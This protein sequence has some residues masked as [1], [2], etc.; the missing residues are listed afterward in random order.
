MSLE[1]A[2]GMKDDK[3]VIMVTG[4]QGEPTSI[5]GRLSAGSHRQIDI[6]KGDTVVLSSHPIPGNEEN[7]SRT[8]NQL[9]AR[10][11]EV[12]YEGLAPVHVSGHASQEEMKLMMHLTRPK[13]FIPIHGE[14]RQLHQHAQLAKQVGI[15]A[16]NISILMNGQSVEFFKG[17]MKLGPVIPTS[18]VFVD[19]SGVGLVNPDVMREREALS[20]DGVLIVNL[21]MDKLTG[22]VSGAPEVVSKGFIVMSEANDMLRELREKIATTAAHANGNLKTDIE[23]MVGNYMYS[24]IRRRPVVIVNVSK[25]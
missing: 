25:N 6:E 24:E 9:F 15:P 16:E 22:R 19:A 14:L 4:S 11:A 2:L 13:Y 10:G 3:V 21:S 5:L 7:V 8:I 1:E 23:K 12:I 18:Y 20:Q 17:E